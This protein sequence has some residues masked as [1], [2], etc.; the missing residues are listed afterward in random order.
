MYLLMMLVYIIHQTAGHN[1]TWIT[2]LVTGFN[3]I[4]ITVNYI[5][6]LQSL[7]GILDTED[8]KKDR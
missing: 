1:V 6:F 3:Q 5:F 4:A 7:L 2:S 8:A